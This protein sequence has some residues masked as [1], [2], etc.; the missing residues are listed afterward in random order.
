MWRHQPLSWRTDF[1]RS[2]D[3]VTKN[4]QAEKRMENTQGGKG[5]N[6]QEAG[7]GV[8]VAAGVS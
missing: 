5:E 7:V 8:A 3:T 4:Q 2:E 6:D 1:L